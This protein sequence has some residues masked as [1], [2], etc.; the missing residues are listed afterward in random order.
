ME[1]DGVIDS[2]GGDH[3]GQGRVRKDPPENPSR[4]YPYL[5]CDGKEWTDGDQIT[6]ELHSGTAYKLKERV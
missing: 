2:P 5:P 4:V 1:F 3:P 6:F